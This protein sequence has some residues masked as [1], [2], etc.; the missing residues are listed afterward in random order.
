MVN[1][2]LRYFPQT[3]PANTLIGRLGNGPG[4]TEAIPLEMVA[5]AISTTSYA[6]TAILLAA[7]PSA[8]SLPNGMTVQTAGR[9]V[10]GDGGGSLFKYDASDITTADNGGTIRVD[11][12]GRRWLA[13]TLEPGNVKLFGAT[14][15]GSTV[16]DQ[17]AIT[18]CVA[19][20]SLTGGKIIFKAPGSYHCKTAGTRPID[21]PANSNNV[22]VECEP[23]AEVVANNL[24]SSSATSDF[25]RVTGPASNI[26]LVNPHFRFVSQSIA[27]DLPYSIIDVRNPAAIA[28]QT[29]WTLDTETLIQAGAITNFN[30]YGGV[31]TNGPG[32]GMSIGGVDGLGLFGV[33]LENTMADGCFWD[34][35][36][37]VKVHGC[38][39]KTTGDDALSGHWVIPSSAFGYKFTITAGNA[40]AGATYTNNGQ[41]F[42]VLSTI[43]AGTVLIAPGTGAPAASG[44][45][46]KS[47]GTGDATLTFSAV[48]APPTYAPTLQTGGD[49][50]AYTFNGQ[51]SSY[52]GNTFDGDN[53]APG[54]RAGGAALA[55]YGVFDIT[56]SGNVFVKKSRGVQ[57]FSGYYSASVSFLASRNIVVD[58][59]T[60]NGASNNIRIDGM[61]TVLAMPDSITR[62]GISVTNMRADKTANNGIYIAG[63]NG[64]W[65]KGLTVDSYTE[66]NSTATTLFWN[67]I[68]C[69][70]SVFTRFKTDQYQNVD[71]GL[72]GDPYAMVVSDLTIQGQ[73]RSLTLAGVFKAQVDYISE[74]AGRHAL[75]AT[76]S[77]RITG[78]FEINN[79]QAGSA[80]GGFNVDANCKDFHL[81]T[82]R[83]Y[84]PVDQAQENIVVIAADNNI[85][86]DDVFF[87]TAKANATDGFCTGAQYL[88]TNSWAYKALGTDATVRSKTTGTFNLVA[89][90][91]TIT[92]NFVNASTHV[93]FDNQSAANPGVLVLGTVVAG[94]SFV[95][96]SM[97]PATDAVKTTDVSLVAYTLKRAA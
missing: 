17:A 9:T 36:K 88:K 27:S 67:V 54:A 78:S 72:T 41:T 90:T 73:G 50:A 44:T 81:T 48:V 31:L 3:L 80:V 18:K 11:A 84:M 70:D 16:N 42:T 22:T 93:E 23:G 15:A 56:A 19:A 6:T 38:N 68:R 49:G 74:G 5:A 52:I 20:I 60:V 25:F 71:T 96:N 55:F 59:T 21:I 95:C 39:F 30:I 79:P 64:G 86:I 89:G 2:G 37:N 34:R 63:T 45:L 28:A 85:A 94:T 35:C 82:L 47:T 62:F 51:G 77:G 40:T 12:Y 1:A 33:K 92:N 13:I 58:G 8:T 10:A 24:T 66:T 32:V 69:Q 43:A 57:S 83:G 97:D 75:E 29:D 76:S 7:F 53:P 61:G 4:A 91:K 46:T 26:T 14:G 87:V 65:A